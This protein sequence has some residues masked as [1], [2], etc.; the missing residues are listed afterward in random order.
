MLHYDQS[1]FIFRGLKC[2]EFC[3]GF[4]AVGRVSYPYHRSGVDGFGIAILRLRFPTGYSN[5]PEDRSV[6]SFPIAGLRDW[7]HSPGNTEVKNPKN[8]LHHG[9]FE[10]EILEC[11]ALSSLVHSDCRISERRKE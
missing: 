10:E 3:H 2:L 1:G 6:P 4:L 8:D 9:M 11:P 7:F 5:G